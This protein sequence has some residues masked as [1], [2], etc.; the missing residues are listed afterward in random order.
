MTGNLRRLIQGTLFITAG[1]LFLLSPADCLAQEELISPPAKKITSFPFTQLTGG[2]IIVKAHLDDFTDTL[3]FVLDTGG[4]GISLDSGTCAY[5]GLKKEPSDRLIRGIAGMKYAEFAKGHSIV[6]PG[7]RIDNL[8]FHIND[9]EILTSAYGIRID[10]IVGYTFFRRYIVMINYDKEIVDVLE[11]GSFKYPKGGFLL[12]PQFTTLPMQYATIK[13]NT[14][15]NAKFYFDTGAGLSLMLN[16]E[17]V[18]DSAII[19]KKRKQYLTEVEGLG[20]KKPT[21]ITVVKEVRL[22]PYKFK[23]VPAHIFNDEFNITPYPILG[24]LI[25]NDLLRR[26]NVILNYPEQQIYIKP[27]THFTDAFDYSYTGLGIYLI[28]GAITVTDI[29]KGSPA[30]ESGL[31]E[32]DVVIGVEN[33]F[34]NNIQTYKTLLQNAKTRVQIVVIRNNKLEVVYLKVKSIL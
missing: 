1:I 20:G 26:F 34:T 27:N 23:N 16:D 22:G 3:N 6:F 9:Y 32:G 8:D 13:D 15:V 21:I 10:G 12:N 24:G 7:L 2:V 19:S 17:I 30:E 28:D 29:I 11:P 14:E 25:G 18:A 33:N 31:R 4:G 5:F